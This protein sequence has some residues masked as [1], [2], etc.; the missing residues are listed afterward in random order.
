M[1][2]LRYLGAV[3]VQIH[4]ASFP[5]STARQDREFR[6]FVEVPQ[7]IFSALVSLI[8]LE[9]LQHFTSAYIKNSFFNVK[10]FDSLSPLLLQG[11]HSSMCGRCI[12]WPPSL[13]REGCWGWKAP[14]EVG[15]TASPS[16]FPDSLLWFF[17][18]QL[19]CPC[20]C[21][22]LA[23]LQISHFL[24]DATDSNVGVPCQGCELSVLRVKV[25]M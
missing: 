1:V 4:L 11:C 18:L 2:Q 23:C 9:V 19:P 24:P 3:T 25:K 5:T 15:G 7:T 12:Q 8:I 6:V 22:L 13:E 10:C 21:E 17:P 14:R 16:P 20:P